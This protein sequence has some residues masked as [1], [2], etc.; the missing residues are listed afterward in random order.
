M[1]YF[2]TLRIFFSSSSLPHSAPSSAALGVWC[3]EPREK[4]VGFRMLLLWPLGWIQVTVHRTTGY[5]HR[6]EKAGWFVLIRVMWSCAQF[7]LYD[8]LSVLFA[9][10]A[11]DFFSCDPCHSANNGV[12]LRNCLAHT[13]TLINNTRAY[14]NVT[15]YNRLV[16]IFI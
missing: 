7:W 9:A 2:E 5:F 3:L 12:C 11:D 8:L 16:S 14:E 15:I 10:T 6:S 1:V 13:T 4:T